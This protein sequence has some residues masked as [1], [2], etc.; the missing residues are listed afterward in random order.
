MI[1]ITKAYD[2]Y[3]EAAYQVQSRWQKLIGFGCGWFNSYEIHG[4][5][6]IIRYG[7]PRSGGMTSETIP[8]Q[9]FEMEDEDEACEAWKKSIAEQRKN[10]EDARIKQEENKERTQL[11]RLKK[12]YD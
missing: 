7:A 6:V 8:I 4:D 9:Y 3:S 10:A 12:K 11:E 5:K 2:E 1:D